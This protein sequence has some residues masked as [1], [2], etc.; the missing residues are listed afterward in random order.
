M[1]AAV[2][3][4]AVVEVEAAVRATVADGSRLGLK[5]DIHSTFRPLLSCMYSTP[6]EATL[7]AA[8][9]AEV[10]LGATVEAEVTVGA[11]VEVE[12]AVGAAVEVELAVGAAVE[13][14]LT[15]ETKSTPLH[16]LSR[17]S[18]NDGASN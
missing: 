14:E 13:A 5:R 17:R 12:L 7:G 15:V 18:C 10:A 2:E 16:I 1:G 8:V 6:S 4:E 11:A 3:L 9:E